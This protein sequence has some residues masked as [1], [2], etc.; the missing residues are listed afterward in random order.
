MCE[1]SLFGPVGCCEPTY[2]ELK[3]S[4]FSYS[5]NLFL[6][7]EPTYEELKRIIVV[8]VESILSV[9]SLP[10]RNWNS[11]FKHGGTSTRALRAYLWGIETQLISAFKIVEYHVAS[12]PMRNWNNNAMRR[13]FPSCFVA[14]LPMRNWNLYFFISSLPISSGCEPTYEELKPKVSP[15]HSAVL[16]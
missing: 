10:M 7:C 9:A 12:L 16:I 13:N 6:C 8:V 3:L 5:K 14:S 15:L 4:F 2:E 11:A 1:D